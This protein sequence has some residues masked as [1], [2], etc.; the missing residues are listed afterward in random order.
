V[1]NYLRENLGME[2]GALSIN[3][4]TYSKAVIQPVINL[5]KLS[6]GL[7]LPIIY[8]QNMFDPNDWYR[9]AGN[10]E[11][12]FG[13]DPAYQGDLMAQ[14]TDFA[15]DLALKIKFLEWGEQRDPFYLKVGN[16][17]T[18]TIGHGLVMRNYANDADF[19]AVRRIGV[20]MGIDFTKTGF[21]TVVND[22]AEPEIFGGRF[23]VRPA[24]PSF[25]L[26][27][28]IS[29]VADIDPAGDLPAEQR[30]LT[31][32]PIFLN[33]GLDLDLPILET[34]FLTF[35]LFGDVAGLLP[36]LREPITGQDA[37]FATDAVMGP[38]GPRNYGFSTGAFGNLLMVDWR[39]EYRYFTGAFEPALYNAM[40]DRLRGHHALRVA[41]YLANPD[42]AEYQGTTS[43]IYGEAGFSLF[44]AVHVEAGYMW[45]WT[46]TDSGVAFADED[47][48]NLKLGIEKGV[49]PFAD[50][51][52][53]IS[54]ERRTFM[55][56]LL[57]LTLD[58]GYA[59]AL[60]DGNTVMKG[61][62]IY[63]VAPTLDLAI[64]VTT[65]TVTN[66]DGTIVYENGAPKVNPSFSVETRVHF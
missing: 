42:A 24:A 62:I 26:A 14:A 10:D 3:G 27:F 33:A 30:D 44:E 52:G 12:S 11:W 40:Y 34:N 36:Y 38:E 4:V 50:I 22:L 15:A 8:Q 9:P 54:Y 32:D 59:P 46:V 64:L 28:G 20:N 41:D 56:A 65:T 21:E 43:G 25:N 6:L 37:G 57:G 23:Y 7:Y 48:I 18:M 19:P 17:K 31:G 58:E 35:V 51:S 61:E 49:I 60:F 1:F 53:S 55:P 13:T 5:G 47:F 16:L 63:P 66:E 29:T 39:L 2:I 45:P